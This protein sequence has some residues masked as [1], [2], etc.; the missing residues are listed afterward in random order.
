MQ[1][2][3]SAFEFARPKVIHG[4]CATGR[5]ETWR[6]EQECVEAVFILGH[7]AIDTALSDRERANVQ[8]A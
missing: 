4:A 7:N 1:T 5:E 2:Y 8:S 6:I 3:Y